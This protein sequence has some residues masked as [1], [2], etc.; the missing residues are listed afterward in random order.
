MQMANMTRKKQLSIGCKKAIIN[1]ANNGRLMQDIALEFCVA[2]STISRIISRY[3]EQGDINRKVG[4]GRP[5]KTTSRLDREIIRQVKVNPFKTA[6]EVTQ[7]INEHFDVNVGV[8]TVRRRLVESKLYARR[9]AKIPYISSINRKKRLDFAKRH[10][11]STSTCGG[12][13]DKGTAPDIKFRQL[14]MGEGQ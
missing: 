4:S 14:N 11:H 7:D 3:R 5:R 13:R 10:M 1:A 12:P 2:T 6:V 8:H 9:P